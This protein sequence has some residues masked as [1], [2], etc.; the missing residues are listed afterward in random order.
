MSTVLVTGGLGYIGSHTC[1]AL[2]EAGYRVVI[3]DNLSN[4]KISVLERIREWPRDGIAFHRADSAMAPNSTGFRR[5]A[6]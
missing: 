3:V 1:V 2:A 4:S 6:V 5:G